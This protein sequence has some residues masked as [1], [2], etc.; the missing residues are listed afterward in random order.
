MLRSMAHMEQ[1][2][3]GGGRLF[4]IVRLKMDH[5]VEANG[6]EGVYACWARSLK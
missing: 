5:I 4:L 3:S 2:A 6:N 1:L